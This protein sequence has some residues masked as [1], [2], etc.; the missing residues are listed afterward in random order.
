[1]IEKAWQIFMSFILAL[2]VW[3]P[4]LF[5][6][7]FAMG[8]FGVEMLNSGIGVLYANYLLGVII[9]YIFGKEEMTRLLQEIRAGTCPAPT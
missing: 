2:L 3:I 8:A 1:M 4:L 5:V 9:S 7:G 6:E